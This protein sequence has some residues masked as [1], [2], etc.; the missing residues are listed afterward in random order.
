MDICLVDIIWDKVVQ[1]GIKH[2]Y[3]FY[4]SKLK[5]RADGYK[6]YSRSVNPSKM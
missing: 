5:K 6:Q 1:H 2:I 4:S 3:K